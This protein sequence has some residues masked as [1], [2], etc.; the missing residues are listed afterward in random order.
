[1]LEDHKGRNPYQYQAKLYRQVTLRL[2]VQLIRSYVDYDKGEKLLII[3]L[4]E[5][6]LPSQQSEKGKQINSQ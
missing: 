1:M 2:T 6:E 3:I 4:Q 5:E